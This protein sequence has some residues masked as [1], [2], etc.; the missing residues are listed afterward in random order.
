MALPHLFPGNHTQH[1][2]SIVL[3]CVCEH[4]CFISIYFVHPLARH[5]L[6]ASSLYTISAY[7]RFQRNSLLS[8]TGGNLY[9]SLSIFPIVFL[10]NIPR[11][12]IMELKEL[13]VLRFLR[14][15]FKIIVVKVVQFTFSLVIYNSVHFAIPSSPKLI[16]RKIC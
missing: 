9:K 7:K 10:G 14:H 1:R 13:T 2:A 4:Q 3:N 15:N 12:G 16:L 5:L 8:E 6:I 11:Y